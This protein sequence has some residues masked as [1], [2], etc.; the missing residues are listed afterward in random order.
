MNK[1]FTLGSCIVAIASIVAGIVYV[2]SHSDEVKLFHPD[3]ARVQIMQLSAEECRAIAVGYE[4]PHQAPTYFVLPI[5]IDRCAKNT[6]QTAYYSS[7]RRDWRGWS[8]WSTTGDRLSYQTGGI[9]GFINK[10]TLD[11]T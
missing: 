11:K 5:T 4:I 9:L 2:E 10:P 1:Q 7:F 8:E 6:I 3:T